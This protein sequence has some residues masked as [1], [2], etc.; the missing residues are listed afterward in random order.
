[1]IEVEQTFSWSP[2]QPLD[3]S[4]RGSLIPRRPG[5]YRIRRIGRDK[6]DY[7][8]ETGRTLTERL[9]GLREI[10][11][12]QMPYSD[13]HTAGPALWALRH[14]SGCSFE[15][16]V[17]PIQGETSWQFL[18]SIERQ[19]QWRMGLEAL[20]I[21]LYRQE[22]GSSPTVNFSRIP[23]GYRK[24]SGNSNKLKQS[25]RFY[26]GGLTSEQE[27]HHLP[28]CSPLGV[29]TEEPES[30]DWCGHQ[31]SNWI[32]ITQAS[33]CL[34]KDSVGLYRLRS[35]N[36]SG[37]LYIG[38]GKIKDRLTDHQRVVKNPKTRKGEIFAS[39]GTLECSWVINELWYKHHRE[40]LENDL[41]AAHLLVAE[42]VPPAQFLGKSNS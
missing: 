35:R 3:N 22:Y 36:Q 25:G 31:W 15:V 16:S 19:K 13:P 2:W 26:R 18:S 11:A 28:S 37:L 24:S 34:A 6:L 32:S 5:L 4:W 9:G 38:Q 14:N 33:T 12:D 10:Y 17:L 29:L 7:I 1:M 23:V 30:L 8:G 20:A 21:S 39:A 27:I 41:I 42:T 40:E